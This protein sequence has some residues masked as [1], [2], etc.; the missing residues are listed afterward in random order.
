MLIQMGRRRFLRR[1]AG[2]TALTSTVP[3]FLHKTGL[4]FAGAPGRDA[5]PIPGLKDDRVLVVVQL[6]GG[7]DGLNTIV[8]HGD[9]LYAKA[10]P[11]LGVDPKKV[12]KLDEHTG[13]HPELVELKGLLDDGQL[14][15]VQNVGYPNPDRSHFRSSE[16]WETASPV[17]KAWTTGWVGRYFDND[18]A[19]AE[20]SVLGLQLGERPAQTFAGTSNR[21]VTI[22]NPAIL[23]W[24]ARG[25]AAEAMRRINRVDPTAID[26]LDFVQRTASDTLRLSKTIGEAMGGAKSPGD[27]GPFELS[28]SLKLVAQMIAAEVPTRVFYVTLGGFDT[29]AAQAN[30]HAALLQE[31]S[32]ALAAFHKDLK[33]RGHLDRTL[34]MTFSEFGRR[35]AENKSAGTDHGTANVMFLMGG[36][37]RPGLHG[38][39]PD[40]AGLDESG[41]LA[42]KIDFRSVY[43]AVLGDW[44]GAD[45]RRVLDGRFD[46]YPILAASSRA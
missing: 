22:S 33:A 18:C 45:A 43:A 46:P 35:V 25:P 13:M 15:I 36:S 26:A 20:S 1:A 30:R 28:Q 37:T 38:D 40:L 5:S 29:H 11:K 42:H 6:A 14:A 27:Y 9:D 4:A 31:L 24:P 10:R 17:D 44:F 7:N 16:V 3:G 23:D 19:G 32:Q 39:R 34:V 21:G 41:D 8:P 2:L 12:L